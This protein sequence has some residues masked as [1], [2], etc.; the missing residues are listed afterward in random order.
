[1]CSLHDIL[2]DKSLEEGIIVLQNGTFPL[3]AK[4]CCYFVKGN[5]TGIIHNNVYIWK[6][7]YVAYLESFIFQ[8]ISLYLLKNYFLYI[9]VKEN[10]LHS[11][12]NI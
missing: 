2:H 12:K 8:I 5:V 1:M 10:M 6:F 9:S 4:K 7:W 3:Y 11:L